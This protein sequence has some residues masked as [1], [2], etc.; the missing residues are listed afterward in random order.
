MPEVFLLD[1]ACL[2]SEEPPNGEVLCPLEI[3]FT[4]PGLASVVRE[5]AGS[6]SLPTVNASRLPETAPRLNDP[7]D[8]PKKVE[9][10]NYRIQE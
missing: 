7:L 9:L 2:G 10:D 5:R 3:L 1:A 6:D 8:R 4:V